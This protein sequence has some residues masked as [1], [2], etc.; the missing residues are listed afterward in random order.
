MNLKT[1]KPLNIHS[2][3]GRTFSIGEAMSYL[4]DFH[5]HLEILEKENNVYNLEYVENEF[6]KMTIIVNRAMGGAKPMEELINH[7]NSLK[8]R[9]ETQKRKCNKNGNSTKSSR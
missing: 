7:Y 9:I 8:E 1:I 5:V 2:I 4:I 3:L 6:S